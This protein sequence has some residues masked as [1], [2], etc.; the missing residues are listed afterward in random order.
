MPTTLLVGRLDAEEIRTVDELAAG[1]I[2]GAEFKWLDGVAHVP[3]LE[4]D[5]A[6]LDAIA[7]FVAIRARS[8]I[9][10]GWLIASAG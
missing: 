2:P 7:A 4:N 10:C 5:P 1:L 6:T 3:H 9:G 8:R